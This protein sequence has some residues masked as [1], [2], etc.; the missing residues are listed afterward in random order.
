VVVCSVVVYSVMVCS[1]AVRTVVVCSVVVY[2]VVVY[3]VVTENQRL[4]VLERSDRCVFLFLEYDFYL[5]RQEE[6]FDLRYKYM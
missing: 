6:T 2:S 1:V 4:L 3:S 5:I